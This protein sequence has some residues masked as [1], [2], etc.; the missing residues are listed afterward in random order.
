LWDVIAAKGFEK[1]MVFETVSRDI[2]ALPKLE[3]TVHVN[4]ALIV[5]FMPNYF[6]FPAEFPEIPQRD[7]PANDDF[8]FKQG[9]TKGLS[10]IQFHDYALAYDSVD[11]PNVQLFKEQIATFKEMLFAARP[12]E[13]Q[14]KDIDFLLNLG[15]LFSLVAYG[16]LILE[17]AE[18][19]GVEDDL[20]AQIFDFM[21]RDFS[22]FALQVYSKTSSTEQQMDYCLKMIKKPTVDPERFERIWQQYAYALTDAYEMN[23]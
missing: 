6:F 1:D 22:K 17:N 16:Q 5:K 12:T 13:E 23:A 20:V 18:I 19:Y 10:K 14:T 11:L 7:D 15:E 21:I 8:L 3:G 4:M 2:R 9:V